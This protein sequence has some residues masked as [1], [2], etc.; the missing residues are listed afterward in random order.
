MKNKQN[1]QPIRYL[2]IFIA[3]LVTMNISIILINGIENNK[4]E[5]IKL[6]INSDSISPDLTKIDS[7]NSQII[8]NLKETES[9][10]ITSYINDN[11]YSSNHHNSNYESNSNN[12]ANTSN[13]TTNMAEEEITCI[14]ADLNSDGI[15][16]SLDIQE[17]LSA[18]AFDFQ[19]SFN[20]IN[21]NETNLTI[22]CNESNN[23]CEKADMNKDGQA[24]FI[25]V[26]I[27][28]FYFQ[29]NC[30]L[31][32]ET[33]NQVTE[34]Q[35]YNCTIT[36]LVKDNVID[37]LDVQFLTSNFQSQDCSTENNWCDNSDMNQ[38]GKVGVFEIYAMK[39]Y[40]LSECD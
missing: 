21:N 1:N 9:T 12:N 25:D 8:V 36:D 20:N 10:P 17:F 18:N 2:F 14:T 5:L 27:L 24:D 3:L 40:F 6:N 4:K 32:N 37:S 34:T 33:F 28:E 11:S 26:L 39:R 35:G 30:S 38:D 15:V 16:D 29:K 31:F 19:E 23:W 13:E 7:S 22:K